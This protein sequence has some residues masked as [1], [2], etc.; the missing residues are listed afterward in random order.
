MAGQTL[1]VLRLVQRVLSALGLVP[2]TTLG[3]TEEDAQV[4]EIINRQYEEVLTEFPW[5]HQNEYVNLDVTAVANEMQM[6]QR[7]VNFEWIKYNE[8]MLQYVTPEDMDRK[9]EDGPATDREP[10]YWTTLDDS[11]IIFDSYLGSLQ[12]NLSTVFA[13]TVPVTEFTADA[14]ITGLPQ[15]LNNLLFNMVMQWAAEEI[16]GDSVAAQMYAR[17]SVRLRQLAKRWAR[18]YNVQPNSFG[19]DYAR[20]RHQSYRRSIDTSRIIDHG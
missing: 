17:N 15:R 4:L 10:T 11:I 16:N 6:P 9:L 18:R 13:Q 14:E 7:V 12:S 3:E 2:I 20:K 8:R 1:T 5:A 19:P